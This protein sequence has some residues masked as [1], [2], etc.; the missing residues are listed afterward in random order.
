MGGADSPEINEDHYDLVVRINNHWL[1]QRGRCEILYHTVKSPH[2]S[3]MDLAHDEQFQ[4]AFAILNV[5]DNAAEIGLIPR[6]TRLQFERWCSQQEPVVQTGAFVQAQYGDCNPYDYSL[7][8]LPQLHQKIGAVLFTGLIG[9]AHLV[10]YPVE[11]LMVAGMDFYIGNSTDANRKEGLHHVGGNMGFLT[12]LMEE[13]PRVFVDP[14]V[15][16]SITRYTLAG[17]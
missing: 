14:A 12:Q 16:A 11:S 2:I 17:C 3:I 7:D 13:D 9:V 5:V 15:M 1:R 10:R 6:P 4:P 8:W